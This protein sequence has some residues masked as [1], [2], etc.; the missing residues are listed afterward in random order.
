MGN[1]QD[2]TDVTGLSC[3]CTQQLS[4]LVIQM[5]NIKK[6]FLQRNPY[7]VPSNDKSPTPLNAKSITNNHWDTLTV[8]RNDFDLTGHTIPSFGALV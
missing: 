4:A 5:Q 1:W 3:I 2:F 7:A 8:L 6:Y